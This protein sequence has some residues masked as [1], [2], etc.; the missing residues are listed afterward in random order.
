MLVHS[1]LQRLYTAPMHSWV[2]PK[3]SFIEPKPLC[4]TKFG[5]LLCGSGGIQYLTKVIYSLPMHFYV[6][7]KLSCKEPKPLQTVSNLVVYCIL[8]ILRPICT[9][10]KPLYSTFSFPRGTKASICSTKPHSILPKHTHVV[11]K[12]LCST[13]TT[14]CIVPK[15][16]CLSSKHLQSTLSW[17]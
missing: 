4:S 14:P 6:L 12:S 16:S 3:L 8:V 13:K 5:S 9:V 15:H 1:I 10:P 11:P 2:V 17:L 7:P